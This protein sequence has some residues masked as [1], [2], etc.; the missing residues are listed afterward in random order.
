MGKY[1]ELVGKQNV[2]ALAQ[3]EGIHGEVQGAG[4]QTECYCPRPNRG[5]GW[6]MQLC[7][8]R[9]LR[10]RCHGGVVTGPGDV[11]IC[12]GGVLGAGSTCFECMCDVFDWLASHVLG[13]LCWDWG[14]VRC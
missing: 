13:G 3:I 5:D 9:W 4:G 1:R 12:T 6:G 2:T 7:Q 8:C 11:V 10:R 14:C